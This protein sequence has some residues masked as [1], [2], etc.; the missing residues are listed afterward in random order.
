MG[1]K[2]HSLRHKPAS[3][4]KLYMNI[5]SLMGEKFALIP[6]LHKGTNNKQRTKGE[7][8][9]RRQTCDAAKTPLPHPCIARLNDAALNL[10]KK[11]PF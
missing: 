7:A 6:K 4:L 9:R 1:V 2:L 8:P 10:D 3:R 11:H 5:S